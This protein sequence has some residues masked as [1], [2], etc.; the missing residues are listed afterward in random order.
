M[1][2]AAMILKAKSVGVRNFRDSAS[3]FIREHKPIVITER[4]V[5]EG[6][7]LPYEDVLELVDILDEL[8]DRELVKDIAEGRRAIKAGAKGISASEVL[9]KHKRASA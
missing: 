5:P 8:N 7:L 2:F 6:L 3:R 9:R 1:T 4:G